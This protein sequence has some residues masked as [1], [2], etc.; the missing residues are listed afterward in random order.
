MSTAPQKECCKVD[1]STLTYDARFRSEVDLNAICL[2]VAAHAPDNPGYLSD[3]FLAETKAISEEHS[4]V[5]WQ[6]FGSE[7]GVMTNFPTYDDTEPCDRYDPRFRPFYVETATPEAKDVV[8]VM[9]TSWSMTGDKLKVAKEAAITVLG[10]MNPKDQ[11]SNS[12]LCHLERVQVSFAIIN[13][14][15]PKLLNTRQNFRVQVE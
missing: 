13:K 14:N 10:T 6:Y 3:R 15:F 7:E 12:Q 5:K 8:L 1:K 2:K 11:V 4:F 9:D